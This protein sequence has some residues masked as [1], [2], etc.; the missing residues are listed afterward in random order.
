MIEGC[1][2]NTDHTADE[3]QLSFEAMTMV[4]RR[5]LDVNEG[6]GMIIEWF[7]PEVQELR[8][9]EVLITP[10]GEVFSAPS[11]EEPPDFPG[12]KSRA[13][14]NVDETKRERGFVFGG[15][16]LARAI[17]KQ[18]EI[19]NSIQSSTCKIRPN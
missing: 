3:E 10:D 9:V 4:L 5:S 2:E 18:K 19:C 12:T 7:H 11:N 17:F 15:E 1:H 8:G 13:V 14:D 16:P 6:S